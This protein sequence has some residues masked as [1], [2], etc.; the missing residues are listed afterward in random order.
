M[1]DWLDDEKITLKT[2]SIDILTEHWIAEGERIATERIIKLLNRK[3][4]FMN[5]DK[6]DGWCVDIKPTIIALIKGEK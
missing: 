2:K 3:C 4:V 5:C 6:T 1:S